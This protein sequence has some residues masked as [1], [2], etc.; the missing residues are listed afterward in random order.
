M[1]VFYAVD[2]AALIRHIRAAAKCVI[3]IA[4]GIHMAV[5]QAL[6]QR[7]SEVDLLDVT[8]VVD[9][10]EDV[11]RIGYGEIAGLQLLHELANKH[12]LALKSQSGLRIGVLITDDQT[13]VWSPTPRAIEAPPNSMGEFGLRSIGKSFPNGLI[14]GTN[15]AREIAYAVM[16]EGTNADPRF[17]EIGSQAVTPE[18]V[19]EAVEALTQNPPIPVDLARVTRVLSTKLQFVEF[20]VVGAKLSRQQLHISSDKLNADA[21]NELKQMIQAQ[22]KPFADLRDE[23]IEVPEFSNG[24]AVMANGKQQRV[25][26]SERSLGQRRVMLEQRYLYSIAGFGNLIEKSKKRDFELEVKA[27][28]VQLEAHSTGLRK[29]L[30]EQAVRI[31]DGAVD[32]IIARMLRGQE[33]SK[34]SQPKPEDLRREFQSGI[35]RVKGS[36]PKASLVFKDVTFEQT[37]NPAFREKVKLALPKAVS[38]RLGAWFEH[39]DAAKETEGSRANEA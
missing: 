37:T 39:F 10:D 30:D 14:V 23:E 5:A 8:V 9:P 31:V 17:A 35:D 28:T 34:R 38:R 7:F 11:C 36:T 21:N 22:L 1:D 12:H 33:N 15:P 20:K 27:L 4:P 19:Q 29:M 3:Y 16:A 18:Q 25:S 32:L 6:G 24:I 13:I 2:D 26:V